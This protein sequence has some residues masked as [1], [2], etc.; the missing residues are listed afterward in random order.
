MTVSAGRTWTFLT[1][2]GHVLICLHRNPQVRIRDIA[3]E[4]GITER[5]VQAILVDLEEGGYVSKDRVG[6]RNEYRI[7]ADLAFR[8]PSE[9]MR[10]IG[11]LLRIFEADSPRISRQ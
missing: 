10:S 7:H 4:V 5:A 6:R 9:A 11:E 8:H 3:A 1:N 2:H